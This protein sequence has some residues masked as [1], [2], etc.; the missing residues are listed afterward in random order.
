MKLTSLPIRTELATNVLNAIIYQTKLIP[1][2]EEYAQPTASRQIAILT[3]GNMSIEAYIILLNQT[4]NDASNNKC[5]R[6][7]ECSIQIQVNTVY[8]ANKG[9]SKVAEEI[10]QLVYNNIYQN[11]NLMTSIIIPNFGIYKSEIISSRGLNYDTDTN[12]VWVNQ[13]ILGLNLNQ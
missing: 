4:A 3:V 13:C 2:Y 10:M 6:K 7:D 1:V 9:G 8:P 5:A 12:R 11:G